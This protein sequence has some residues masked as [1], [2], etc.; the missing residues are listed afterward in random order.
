MAYL[1]TF[2]SVSGG[3]S[4]PGGPGGTYVG[5]SSLSPFY[6]APSAVEK[7]Q[8]SPAKYVAVSVVTRGATSVGSIYPYGWLSPPT[9]CGDRGRKGVLKRARF[10]ARETVCC[11]SSPTLQVV[12][13]PIWIDPL[14]PETESRRLWGFSFP[15]LLSHFWRPGLLQAVYRF[16]KDVSYLYTPGCYRVALGQQLS[17]T[18]YSY[19]VPVTT[20]DSGKLHIRAK[21][22]GSVS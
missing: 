4:S 18:P 9:V 15:S 13:S 11:F 10:G 19:R 1:A 12:E 7:H 16:G 22:S 21:T 6:G 17:K 3:E 20:D 14:G 5:D 2:V 8:V